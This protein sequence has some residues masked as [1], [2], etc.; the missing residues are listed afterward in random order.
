MAVTDSKY[1]K[2]SDVSH[3]T[4]VYAENPM[5]TQILFNTV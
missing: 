1:H 4:T 3:Y 2:I 5:M